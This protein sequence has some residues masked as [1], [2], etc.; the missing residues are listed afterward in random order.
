[1]IVID[2]EVDTRYMYNSWPK[3]I[4]LKNLKNVCLSPLTTVVY[5]EKRSHGVHQKGKNVT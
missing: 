5:S 3:D 4:F 1:M 2:D